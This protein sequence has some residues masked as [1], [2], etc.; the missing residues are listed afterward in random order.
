MASYTD[1]ASPQKYARTGGLLYLFI[2]VA[3]GFGELFVRNRLIVWGDAAATANNILSSETL[4]RVGLVGEM[5][6]CVCD[7]ALALILYVLLR[8]V[9]KNLA[10]L[11]A[12]FRLTFVGIYGVTKLFEIAALVALGG[13][14]YLKALGPSQLH[15]LAYVSLRVHSLGY[16]ASLLFF[17]VCCILFGHL[18][19]RSGYLPRLL[20]ILLAIAGYGYVGFSVAQLLSPAFAAR[21]LFPWVFPVAFL[22]E[23]ALCLWLLVKGVNMS[24]WTERTQR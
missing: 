15:D 13:G 8:P 12:F 4:F 19:E 9:S 1:E 3:A 11:A 7:V 22:A 10:L 5:L 16:G 18:I 6:T 21:V 23:S 17:G 2:I 14:D 24:N 20:G